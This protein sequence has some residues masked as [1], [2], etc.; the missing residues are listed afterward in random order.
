[1]ALILNIE[2]A[3]EVCSVALAENGSLLSLEEETKINSHSSTLTILISRVFEKTNRH[4]I[5]LDGIA[6]SAGPGSFTGLRIGVSTAKGLCYSLDKP[7]IA[8]PTLKAMAF[9]SIEEVKDREA[10]YC[11][12]IESIKDEVFA[13]LYSYNLEEIV[14]EESCDTSL[15][16]LIPFF[17]KRTVII[18]G[19]GLD[20]LHLTCS[21]KIL[22]ISNSSKNMIRLSETLFNEKR[23]CSLE[24]FEPFYM[25]NFI[26][27]KLL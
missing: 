12:V 27:R 25:K 26:P 8:V 9:G 13:G 21:P 14:P 6:V 7:L 23:F 19:S 5:D 24:N 2:T 18:S 16:K 15:K 3:T 4:L 10:Y 11:S 20:K 22:S 1:L 17:N